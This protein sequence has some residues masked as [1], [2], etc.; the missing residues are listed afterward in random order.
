[1]EE[2][3]SV[4]KRLID[5]FSYYE[6]IDLID[7][8]DNSINENGLLH[9]D[10]EFIHYFDIL[11]SLVNDKYLVDGKPSNLG[12]MLVE[13]ALLSKKKLTPC[14]CLS[15]ILEQKSKLGFSDICNDI[16]FSQYIGENVRMSITK[17][18]DS[19]LMNFKIN[20]NEFKKIDDVDSFNYEL[21]FCLLHEITHIY[22]FTRSEQDKNDFD[23]L[24]YYDNQ[25]ANAITK[26]TTIDRNLMFHQ[27]LLSE[28]MADEQS[29]VF[30]MNLI[31]KHPEYFNNE[32]IMRK[33][34]EYR[35][36]KDKNN[37][38]FGSDP[39]KSFSELLDYM[40]IMYN[41]YDSNKGREIIKDVEDIS[42]KEEDIIMALQKKGI[43]ERA[44]DKYYNIYL[45]RLYTFDG[46]NIIFDNEVMEKSRNR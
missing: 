4:L 40:K 13:N 39:R 29:H 23:K 22:Q 38:S 20:W 36:R 19:D 11:R 12:H 37:G 16:T 44:F 2:Y 25:I 3:K 32:I 5:N 41:R 6:F 10:S 7:K 1:M 34:E 24:A 33:K 26:N 43:S 21:I 45:R 42:K 46:E 15:F 9:F 17:Y 35:Q 27:S 14:L 28:F 8:I 30:M 31:N 18:T